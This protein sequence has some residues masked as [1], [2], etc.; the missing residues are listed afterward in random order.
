MDSKEKDIIDPTNIQP[1]TDIQ[2]L[3]WPSI[4]KSDPAI[5][6]ILKRLNLVLSKYSGCADNH[7]FFSCS[8]H[9]FSSGVLFNYCQRPYNPS[10]TVRVKNPLAASRVTKGIFYAAIYETNNE[11]RKDAI[12]IIENSVRKVDDFYEIEYQFPIHDPVNGYVV[13]EC[14]WRK[15]SDELQKGD[16]LNIQNDLDFSLF[17]KEAGQP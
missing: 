16:G 11:L 6:T 8:G 12:G 13:L 4:D 17:V 9:V 3:L 10:I 7:T 1:E 15:V 2:K 5:R 14:F